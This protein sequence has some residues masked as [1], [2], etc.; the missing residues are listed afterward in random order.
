MC[1]ADISWM[2]KCVNQCACL[3]LMVATVVCFIP[4]GDG[5]HPG[6]AAGR[7]AAAHPVAA[8][9]AVAGD[10]LLRVPA[11]AAAGRC[12]GWRAHVPAGWSTVMCAASLPPSARCA[13][14]ATSKLS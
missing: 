8:A 1:A 10:G 6:A 2:H 13:A 3:E 4:A 5:A 11:V 7:A 12:T 9:G 14:A